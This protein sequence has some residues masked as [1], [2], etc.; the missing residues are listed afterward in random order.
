TNRSPLSLA[1]GAY[2]LTVNDNTAAH[3]FVLR[4]CPGSKA[5]CDAANPLRTTT[6]VTTQAQ[7]ATVSI[8]LNL[9]IG[10]YRLYC[11]VDAH[12]SRGMFADFAAGFPVAMNSAPLVAGTQ[13]ATVAYGG[14]FSPALT[15]SATDP[16]TAGSGLTASAAGLPAGLS[17]SVSSTSGAGILPGT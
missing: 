5:P 12:E 4:S 3:D 17:L 8:P 9:A 13:T 16:D 6:I 7:V 15:V 14:S 1:P 11:S 2:M 10:T